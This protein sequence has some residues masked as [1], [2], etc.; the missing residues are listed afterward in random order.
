MELQLSDLQQFADKIIREY[1]RYLASMAQSKDNT[2]S[3]GDKSS[4]DNISSKGDKSS[5]DNISSKVSGARQAIGFQIS[6]LKKYEIDNGLYP[7]RSITVIPNSSRIVDLLLIYR[8]EVG[9]VKYELNIKPVESG[10]YTIV[11]NMISRYVAEEQYNTD[12]TITSILTEDIPA[13]DR[14]I[15]DAGTFLCLTKDTLCCYLK[16]RHN[17]RHCPDCCYNQPHAKM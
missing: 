3:K 14:Q 12:T 1:K 17:Q 15:N 4:K 7:L 11:K 6:A 13:E 16:E 8:T 10:K 9:K 2:S 5:K